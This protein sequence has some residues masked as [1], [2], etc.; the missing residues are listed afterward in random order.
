MLKKYCV[1]ALIILIFGAANTGTIF[2]ISQTENQTSSAEKA[3][4]TVAKAGVGEKTRVKMTLRD[5]TK[6]TGYIKEAGDNSFTLIDKKTRN[7]ATVLYADVAKIKADKLSTLAKIGIGI[8]IG[9]AAYIV[10]IA[11]AT[12]GFQKTGN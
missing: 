3:K 7:T 5:G 4:R 6:L 11:V 1:F 12:E 10:V 8:G 2:A 9:V